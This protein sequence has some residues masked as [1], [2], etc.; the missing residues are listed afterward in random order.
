VNNA[1]D[2]EPTHSQDQTGY[3]GS[4]GQTLWVG[5]SYSFS[6]TREF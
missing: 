2:Q 3:R 6:Y 5:R 4:L 1:Y